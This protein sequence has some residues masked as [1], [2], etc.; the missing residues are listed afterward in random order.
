M[1]GTMEEVRSVEISPYEARARIQTLEK[2]LQEKNQYIRTI[3]DKL[4]KI[5]QQRITTSPDGLQ[6]YLGEERVDKEQLDSALK[7]S[8]DRCRDLEAQLEQL[9]TQSQAVQKELQD[10]QWFLGEERAKNAAIPQP[11]QRLM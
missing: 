1:G 7:N 11:I 4:R 8:L 6:W 5:K 9:R 2:E 3:D 10:T